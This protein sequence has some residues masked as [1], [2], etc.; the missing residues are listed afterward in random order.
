MSILVAFDVHMRD[1]ARY[2]GFMMAVYLPCSP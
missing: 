2:Q 1:V